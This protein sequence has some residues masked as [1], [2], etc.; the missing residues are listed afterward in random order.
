MICQRFCS[1]LL[2]FLLPLNFVP[3]NRWQISFFLSLSFIFF[4]CFAC[5]QAV[6]DSLLFVH[7]PLTG[8]VIWFCAM[9]PL[10]EIL[11][12]VSKW[13]KEKRNGWEM[14]GKWQERER[15]RER[16]WIFLWCRSQFDFPDRK[17]RERE[18]ERE[19][20]EKIFL[21]R[22]L[23]LLPS[24]CAIFA[25][26][27]SRDSGSYIYREG[28]WKERSQSKA[29]SVVSGILI[30]GRKMLLFCSEDAVNPLLQGDWHAHTHAYRVRG[31]TTAAGS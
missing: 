21:S 11:V 12:T 25:P 15:E 24:F 7:S 20:I 17:E 2:S 4:L 3:W 30:L 16:E 19:W 9:D 6:P 23:L 8:L 26:S 10:F 27:W 1:P 13:G 28:M 18:R 31:Q 14:A 22:S 29:W 5:L